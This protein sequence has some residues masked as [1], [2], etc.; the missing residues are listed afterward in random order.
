MSQGGLRRGVPSISAETLGTRGTVL[1]PDCQ[2]L[3]AHTPQVREPPAQAV[4]RHEHSS[5]LEGQGKDGG[6]G[7]LLQ[8]PPAQSMGECLSSLPRDGARPRLRG[9]LHGWVRVP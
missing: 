2:G 1:L 3:Q 6:K 9:L 8:Q 7:R 4:S 5:V